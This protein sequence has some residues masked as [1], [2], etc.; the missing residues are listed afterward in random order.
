MCRSRSGKRAHRLVRISAHQRAT[1]SEIRRYISNA[2][3]HNVTVRRIYG[4]RWLPAAQMIWSS[5]YGCKVWEKKEYMRIFDWENSLRI[6]VSQSVKWLAKVITGLRIWAQTE[7][8]FLFSKLSRISPTA[9]LPPIWR[10]GVPLGWKNW[11]MTWN[12]DKKKLRG[13]SPRANCTD[14]AAAAGRRS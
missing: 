1:S 13:L 11:D 8:S 12:R 9:T 14:R 2:F 10:R 5:P 4:G 3:F 6:T 7:T